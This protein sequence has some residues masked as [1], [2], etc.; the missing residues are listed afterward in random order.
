MI[1]MKVSK[2]ENG[3]DVITI[4]TDEGEFTIRFE[5]V[6][7]LF[8]CYFA[9]GSM[10]DAPETKTFIITEENYYLYESLD[11][12]FEAIKS[13]KPYGNYP[14]DDI[15]KKLKNET[16][17]VSS[18]ECNGLFKDNIIEWHSD[19]GNEFDK[20]SVLYLKKEKD[21]FS[22]SFRKNKP[23][24]EIISPLTYSIRFRTSGSNYQNYYI[25]FMN[26]YQ[27]LKQ[28]NSQISIEECFPTKVKTLI[29]N[30]TK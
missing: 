3:Y 23:E 15:N 2:Q 12:L 17:L 22:I 30:K 24:H 25:C 18:S 20:A 21:R 14:F 28:Y 8:W 27:K 7:D 10:L 16:S 9:K 13:S 5:G 1:N 4:I 19:D 26:M 6:Q 29:R 11:E